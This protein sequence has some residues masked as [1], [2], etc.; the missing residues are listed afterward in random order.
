MKFV[1]VSDEEL[2]ITNNLPL[3]ERENTEEIEYLN[4]ICVK[5]W[6][7]EYLAYQNDKIGIWILHIAKDVGTSVHCHF[8]KDT[9]LIPISGSFKIELYNRFEILN[10][11]EQLYIPRR[12]FHGI[13]A[14]RN[15][16][17]LMEIEI[18]TDKINYTDKNDLFRFKDNIYTRKDKSNYASSVVERLPFDNEIMN[19]HT[20]N[21]FKI[22]NTEISINSLNNNDI[23]K[24]DISI[25]LEGEIFQESTKG[26]GSIIC[27]NRPFS[28]LTNNVKLLNISNHFYPSINKVVYSNRHLTDLLELNKYSN[29]G[30]TSGCFDIIHSGHIKNLKICKKL[31]GTF[32]VCL[33]SDEQVKRLKG[34]E[35]PV[36]SLIDR[37]I[38]L[39]QFNFI[40]YILLY[41]EEDDKKEKTLDE[42]MV[43]CNPETW[44]KG[45]DYIEDDIRYKHPSLKNICL[46][47]LES[48]KSTTNIVNKIKNNQ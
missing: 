38:M 27:Q 45:K 17:V 48:G 2:I 32:I 44:F 37:A 4:K 15:D 34:S 23:L 11:L 22:Y 9:L 29:I 26:E 1:N 30:L 6:G 10:E 24:S 41:D 42:I 20:N 39:S 33:S 28:I 46:I 25:I 31:S 8:K 14:Y 35:R 3:L 36:N 19:M 12:A 7:K 40:D 43:I 18:Y 13:T 21:F 5:P 16:S 47:E